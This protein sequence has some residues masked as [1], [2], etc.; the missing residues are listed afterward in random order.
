MSANR[1]VNPVKIDESGNIEHPTNLEESSAY[2]KVQQVYEGFYVRFDPDDEEGYRL[3]AGANCIIGTNLYPVFESEASDNPLV[4]IDARHAQHI[5]QC[6]RK[7]S[8]RLNSLKRR[9]W[10]IQLNLSAV[11]YEESSQRFWGEAAIIA[12]DPQ[13]NCDLLAIKTFINH[14]VKRIRGGEHPN[15]ALSQKQFEQVLESKGAWYLT[16]AVPFPTTK[17]GEI[18]FKRK[19]SPAEH[20]TEAAA[21]GNKGCMVTGIL[22][23][24]VVI[25]AAVWWFFLR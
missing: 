14:I 24:M 19:M 17:S 6:D 22:F 21:N 16:K 15:P 5:S 12:Y 25:A 4:S 3:L 23:W 13:A 20:L 9:G 10:V 11:F 18:I 8:D 2:P 1:A 7:T